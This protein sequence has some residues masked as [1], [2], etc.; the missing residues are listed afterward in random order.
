MYVK[1]VDVCTEGA[2][3]PVL[4]PFSV[5]TVLLRAGSQRSLSAS[6]TAGTRCLRSGSCALLP[7][8]GQLEH[9]R[10]EAEEHRHHKDAHHGGSHGRQLPR[11]FL[12]RGVCF[13]ESL[14]L[15]FLSEDESQLSFDS[16]PVSLVDSIF[17][18]V[19]PN[20]NW[21]WSHSSNTSCIR[22]VRL[23]GAW[24]VR[25]LRCATS[26]GA[27]VPGG[28]CP[29]GEHLWCGSFLPTFPKSLGTS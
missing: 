28:R 17:L 7:A 5:K 12:A 6:L 18:E 27:P 8:D 29:R 9:H 3:D 26:Q 16:E 20:F 11:E 21:V 23:P 2:E 4:S 13:F 24:W 10:D 25:C 22:K 14:G 1:P 19:K 15:P